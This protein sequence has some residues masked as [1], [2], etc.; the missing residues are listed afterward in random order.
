M[1]IK[2]F[3]KSAIILLSINCCYS[4]MD[5]SMIQRITL[6]DDSSY[7]GTIVGHSG[8]KI[9]FRTRSGAEIEIDKISIKKVQLIENEHPDRSNIP[10]MYSLNLDFGA[11]QIGFA[12][13]I[14]ISFYFESCFVTVKYMGTEEFRILGPTPHERVWDIGILYGTRKELSIGAASISAGIAITGGVRRGRN[15]INLGWLYS[16][17]DAMPYTTVGFPIECKL[18]LKSISFLGIGI[19]VFA[20]INREHAIGGALICLEI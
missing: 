15:L 1:K 7:A 4:Q 16:E 18:V 17:Y 20:N 3:F 11:S 8:D 9:K 14:G 10:E 6:T 13:Q 5:T 2:I 19:C 12:H